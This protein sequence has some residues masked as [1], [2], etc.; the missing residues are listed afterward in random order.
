M[1]IIARDLLALV[2][3]CKL[4]S[5]AGFD[6]EELLPLLDRSMKDM[7]SEEKGALGNSNSHRCFSSI[8]INSV[9]RVLACTV[10]YGSKPFL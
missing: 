2:D 7:L 4:I 3:N 10:C 9:Y 5:L 1:L 6:L 8:E